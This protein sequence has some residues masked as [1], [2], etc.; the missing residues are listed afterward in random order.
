VPSF[1]CLGVLVLPLIKSFSSRQIG[2][3]P[4]DQGE[5]Y[6]EKHGNGKAPI[7]V[8]HGSPGLDHSY[9]IPQMY[10]L[11]DLNRSLIFYDQRGG[12]NSLNTPVNE[13][14]MNSDQ[15]VE[16]LEKLRQHLGIDSF[17]LTGHSWGGLL[18]MKYAISYPGHLKG[19]VLISTA[20]ATYKGQKEYMDAM[21][22]MPKA[23]QDEETKAFSDYAVFEKLNENQIEDLYR[24]IFSFSFYNPKQAQELGFKVN[25]AAAQTGFKTR[26]LLMKTS[27]LVPTMNLLPDL[28]KVDVPTLIIHGNQDPI[29]SWTATEIKEAM[30][31][32]SLMFFDEYGHFPYIEKR[33]EFIKVINSFIENLPS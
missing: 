16:D 7:I 12:G 20:P 23:Y 1:L 24:K 13:T 31:K 29:P 2:F 32:A 15:Y 6:F 21:A 19:L 26:D 28:R 14:L 10:E 22:N 8:S 11:A 30:P 25:V 3:C 4:I 18:A 5:M 9:L 17:V 27:W 33:D